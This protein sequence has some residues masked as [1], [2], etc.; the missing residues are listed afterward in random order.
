MSLERCL[1]IGCGGSGAKTLAYMMDHLRSILPPEF[2]DE[3]PAGWQF[4][5]VDVPVSEEAGPEGIP[6]VSRYTNGSYVGLGPAAGKYYE[7]DKLVSDGLVNSGANLRSIASWVPKQPQGLNILISEGAGQLRAVG[8]MVTLSSLGS[9]REGLESARQAMRGGD[10]DLYRLAGL[11]GSEFKAAAPAPLVL[12]VSSMAG[13]AGASMTID[14]CRVLTMLPGINSDKVALFLATPDTFTGLDESG[15]RGVFGNALAMVGEMVSAQA[16]RAR[17]DVALMRDFQVEVRDTPSVGRVFPVGR[18]RGLDQAEI[19]VWPNDVYRALGRGLGALLSSPKALDPFVTYDMTNP[20]PT[21]GRFESFG[22]GLPQR[23]LEWYSFGYSSL[24]MGRDRY[25]EYAA[26]R[27]ARRSID[28]LLDGYMTGVPVSVT[29]AMRLREL[30]DRARGDV[31]ARL[32]LRADQQSYG[33]W[34]SSVGWPSD[35]LRA[36]A[37]SVADDAQQR[38]PDPH[39]QVAAGWLAT[40]RAQLRQ[41]QK[42]LQDRIS[43]Q[44]ERRLWEYQRSLVEATLLLTEEAISSFGLPYAAELLARVDAALGAMAEAARAEVD[45]QRHSVPPVGEIDEKLSGA[46]AQIKGMVTNGAALLQELGEGLR[47]N[48]QGH[49]SIA[50]IGAVAGL[51]ADFRTGFLQ[52]LRKEIEE[53]RRL[54]TQARQAT[55]Q[56]APGV[57][58]VDS[59]FYEHWPR[60]DAPVPARF[61]QA[62]NEVLVTE[63]EQYLEQYAQD[64]SRAIDPHRMMGT[65]AAEEAAARLIVTGRW[66]TGDGSQPPGGLIVEV[67][68][69]G[70]RAFLRNP[71]TGASLHPRPATIRLRVGTEDL[72]DRSR[73]FV[74]RRTYS[75]EEFCS[76]SLRAYVAEAPASQQTPRR[77]ELQAKFRTVLENAKPLCSIEPSVVQ[78]VYGQAVKFQYKFSDIPFAGDPL[79]GGFEDYLVQTPD[80][81]HQAGAWSPGNPLSASDATRIDVFG[82]Y[83]HYAPIVYASLINPIRDDYLK[84][85]QHFWHLR[86][87]RPLGA[88]LVMSEVERRALIGG[89]FVGQVTGRLGVVGLGGAHPRVTIIP[90]WRDGSRTG[91]GE[92]ALEFPRLLTVPKKGEGLDLMACVLETHL[93]ALTGVA[94]GVD[95]ALAPYVA[96]RELFQRGPV[97]FREDSAG[98]LLRE[99]LTDERPVSGSRVGELA[100]PGGAVTFDERRDAVLGFLVERREWAEGLRGRIGTRVAASEALLSVDIA[101]DISSV[102]DELIEQVRAITQAESEQ[103]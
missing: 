64:V 5:T 102:L 20:S 67:D 56:A 24:S 95:E 26:Q 65:L 37:K 103:W 87:S 97:D 49:L 41:R 75:F 18:T 91:P 55:G 50:F 96:L 69:W 4:V 33:E 54:L 62:A 34:L 72:L 21:P 47:R 2:G 74:S 90:A 92:S 51:W 10:N 44:V 42:G 77:A 76:T 83:S 15:R 46:I 39:N 8:R 66:D 63:P 23:E 81:R 16:S 71:E 93:A 89:W 78:Q 101:D 84:Q 57:A 70:P 43:A 68:Q 22:W 48:V 58:R 59:P 30:A 45:R 100:K 35:Q 19:G 99:L 27:L 38:L 12:V 1:I 36:V 73:Q 52:E 40:I 6:A 28:H 61:G 86:R 11:L 79:A 29:G 14:V 3:L 31:D 7:L 88:S 53:S 98:E 17:D 94:S 13:G 60:S 9:L 85:G 32:G 80:I 82:S 25:R